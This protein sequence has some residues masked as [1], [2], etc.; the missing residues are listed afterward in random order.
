M[1]FISSTLFGLINESSSVEFRYSRGCKNSKLG[2]GCRNLVNGY[3]DFENGLHLQID[4][5]KK[6]TLLDLSN[7]DFNRVFVY[8]LDMNF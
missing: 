7:G 8:Y 3:I 2:N 6:P 1:N 4:Y 5:S